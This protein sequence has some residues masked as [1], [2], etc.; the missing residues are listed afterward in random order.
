MAMEIK[1]DNFFYSTC[2]KSNFIGVV[3]R[4]EYWIA[5]SVCGRID[6]KLH[7]YQNHPTKKIKIYK[8][9]Q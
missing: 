5:C 3:G 1:V 4:G 8:E 2:C 7:N 6:W 9:K